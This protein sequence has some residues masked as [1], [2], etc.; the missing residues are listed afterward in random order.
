[1]TNSAAESSLGDRLRELARR[2]ALTG[3]PLP[4]EPTLAGE[5]GV[6]R[7]ALREALARLESEGF[8]RRRQGADTIVNP[9]AFEIGVRFDQQVEFA[10]VLR[11]AGYTPTVE[12]LES[13]PV[14]LG[15]ADAEVLGVDAG[16]PAFRTVKRWLADGRAAMVAVDVI[17]SEDPVDVERLDPG[18][19][20][21]ELVRR[22]R[23][24]G[25]EWELAWPGAALAPA[26]VRRWLDLPTRSA[27]LTLDLIGVSRRGDRVYRAMEY[28]VPGF[29]RPGFVR[30]VRQ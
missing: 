10:Q 2:A 9:G 21:F 19:G 28:Q 23:G 12:V 8:L 7:P 6:S 16:G 29:V 4:G 30:S 24:V 26:A 11:D 15:P 5:L 25:A 20:L 3:E 17:P 27:V 22:I 18:A 14:A 13:G 1:M